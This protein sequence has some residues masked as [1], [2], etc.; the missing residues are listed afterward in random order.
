[1]SKN[2]QNL[3][4]TTAAGVLAQKLDA[5]DGNPNGKIS[6]SIW[7]DF[8]A[9]K[10][11]KSVNEFIDVEDAMNS[12]TTYFVK[13]TKAQNKDF[14]TLITEWSD[15]VDK[16]E[17]KAPVVK[18]EKS[19][20]AIT[21]EDK[22]GAKEKVAEEQGLRPTN[23]KNF[24]YSEGEKEH[25]KW[26][27]KK[28]KF[29]KCQN[30]AFVAKDGTYRRE[31][32][33]AD[34]S[35]KSINYSKEGYPTSMEARNSEGKPYL[36]RDFSAK[37]LGLRETNATQAKGIYYDEKTKMH[38]K[39]NEKTHTFAALN[40]NVGYVATDGTE[41]AAG[42]EPTA[43]RTFTDKRTGKMTSREEDFGNVVYTY[44]AKGKNTKE[45][46]KD[47]N[48]KVLG[49]SEYTYDANGNRTKEVL[50][51]K[52]GKIFASINFTYNANGE[53]TDEIR[54][55]YA[56]DKN[57]KKSKVIFKDANDNI[58]SSIE[59]Q[60]G[61]GYEFNVKWDLTKE[62]HKDNNNKKTKEVFKYKSGITIEY[63]YDTD[64]NKVKEVRKN[65][66]GETTELTFD[67]NG[68]KISET[69][70]YQ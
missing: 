29:I 50:K 3:L 65:K 55:E 1:M 63:T 24:Y 16:I 15:Q 38:Y 47:K 44:N 7:N 66:S 36:D 58:T 42:E 62:I 56:Y 6:A 9:D 14:N 10:G 45:V 52:D 32:K 41:Y 60:Y 12:L 64:G 20:K 2:I 5:K 27:A 61:T 68:K 28:Q 48:G 69:R 53:K 34:G 49:S 33:N 37:N 57:G 26:D 67:S 4:N 8:I 11:G 51:D 25:Y 31:Y 18:S 46:R 13:Q 35:R 59:Y 17:E 30:V 21:P 23:N 39:W 22:T 54:K 40:K 43:I 70:K 19:N